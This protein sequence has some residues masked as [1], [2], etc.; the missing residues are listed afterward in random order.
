MIAANTDA[1]IARYADML[2]ALGTV[3]RLRVE[4]GGIV[5]QWSGAVLGS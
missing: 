3:T 4:G 1:E 5:G 2:A